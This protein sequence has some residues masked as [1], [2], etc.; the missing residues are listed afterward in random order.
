VGLPSNHR[1][2]I[3]STAP[4]PAV[5]PEAGQWLE[6]ACWCKLF[7][8]S[9]STPSKCKSHEI[10]YQNNANEGFIFVPQT[11]STETALVSFLQ[12]TFPLFT[13]NDI[14]KILLFYP[15]TNATDNPNATLFSTLGDSGLTAINQSDVGAGQQQ[16]A[17]NIYAETTF[18]C[19]AYWM[20]EAFS[21]KG[22]NSYKYQYSVPA[23]THGADVTGYFGPATPNQGPDFE[24]AF[25]CMS[26]FC[27]SFPF[28]LA[29]YIFHFLTII[30][31]YN[32]KQ[33]GATW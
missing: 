28:S 10:L 30:L 13:N 26:S 32:I 1:R 4:E 17:N 20:A 16:R 3:R 6:H 23:A 19:P 2:H 15:S 24:L 21:D 31:T 22:R 5:T 8:P 29:Y 14:A 27:F 12:R 33:S 9:V 7:P 11:I 18:V 25:M